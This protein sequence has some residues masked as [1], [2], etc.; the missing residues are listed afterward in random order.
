MGGENGTAVL[1]NFVHARK[2]LIGLLPNGF[3]YTAV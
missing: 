2:N 1:R 3:A